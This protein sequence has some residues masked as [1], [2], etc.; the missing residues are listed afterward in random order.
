MSLKQRMDKKMWF[1][2][3]MENFSSIKNKIFVFE[4]AGWDGTRKY[5]FE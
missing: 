2:Y 3:I 1:I 4:F 5:H